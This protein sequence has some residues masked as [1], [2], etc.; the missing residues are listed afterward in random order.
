MSRW[1]IVRHG[2]TSWNVEG[3][4]QGHTDIPLSE[5]GVRQA[6]ALGARLATWDIRAA[7]TSD[8]KRTLETAQNVLKGHNLSPSLSR[9]LR[10]FSYGRWE[11]MTHQEV[12]EADPELYAEMLKRKEDFAPPGG[13]SLRDLMVRIG[14]FVAGLK[15]AHRDDIILI[16]GH[17]GSLRVLLTCLL[18][19]PPR[20]AWRFF[21][22]TGSLSVVDCYPDNTVLKLFNDTSHWGG[23]P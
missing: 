10:E 3:R 8:L 4:I 11:G 1:L 16:T 7:Y 15:A 5:K 22:S 13:E 14:G 17:G 23:E 2:E 20:A 19:L 12:K 9:E 18:E 21:L 6:E